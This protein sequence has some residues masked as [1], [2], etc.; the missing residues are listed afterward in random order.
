MQIYVMRKEYK[1][2]V[3]KCIVTECVGIM[4]EIGSVTS[5][6]VNVDGTISNYKGGISGSTTE[7]NSSDIDFSENG[8]I[9][10]SKGH[11]ILWDDEEE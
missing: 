9:S 7:G 8:G 10:G 3:T 5:G 6:S 11:T 4:A 2:P 1:K